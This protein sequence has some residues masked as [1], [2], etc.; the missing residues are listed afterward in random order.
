MDSKTKYK[1]LGV[2]VALGLV[3]ILYPFF[4]NGEDAPTTTALVNPPAFPEQSN[5]VTVSNAEPAADSVLQ[6]I[7]ETPA[8]DNT[9]IANPEVQEAAP[10]TAENEI[11]PTPDDTIQK[12]HSE[13]AKEPPV[14]SIPAT[15]EAKK[16][17][18][19]AANNKVKKVIKTITNT[20]KLL[21]YKPVIQAPITEDGLFELKYPS[22]VVQVGSFNKK[23]NAVALVNQLR[24]NG[25]SAF[26]QKIATNLGENTRVYVGPEKKAESARMLA[27][28]LE[29][30]LHLHGIVISYKP[31]KL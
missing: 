5:Q 2:F 28:Q 19:S 9:P 1:I 12:T 30:N 17:I 13:S 24:M 16:S 27:S 23:I 21:S 11:K 18:K 4:Q 29:N 3:V 25:Y 20:P 7:A 6:P 10:T 8:A 26:M 14:V 31:L 15:P 22:Y